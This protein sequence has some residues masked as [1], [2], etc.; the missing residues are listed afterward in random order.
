MAV[1]VFNNFLQRNNLKDIV[2]IAT[3]EST[4]SAQDAATTHNVPVSNIIKSLLVEFS[5]GHCE[6]FLVPGDKKLELTVKMKMANPDKVKE[7][8]GHSIGGVTPFGHIAKLKINIVDGFNPSSLLY[9]AAGSL[10]SVFP[11]SYQRLIEIVRM[12]NE[13]ELL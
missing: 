9:G 1:Q 3:K 2:V 10:N 13:G 7:L 8:T 4:K 6:M 12:V 11:I 5:D